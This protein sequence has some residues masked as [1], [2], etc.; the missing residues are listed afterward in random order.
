M[1]ITTTNMQLLCLASVIGSCKLNYSTLLASI[2][3][4]TYNGGYFSQSYLIANG[5]QSLTEFRRLFVANTNSCVIAICY[6]LLPDHVTF[7]LR[8]RDDSLGKNTKMSE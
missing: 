4:T 6:S 5:S 8:L 1:A 2:S 3:L 7:G